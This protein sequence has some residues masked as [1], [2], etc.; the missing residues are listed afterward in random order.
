MI[1][2]ALTLHGCS[3]RTIVAVK[4]LISAGIIALAVAL[5]QVVHIALGQPGGAQFLPMYLPVLLGACLLGARWGAA[6]GVMSPLVS[7]LITTAAGNAMPAAGRLPFMMLELLVF[8]VVAGLFADAISRKAV[9]VSPAVLA[10][11]IC[12]RGAF[13][14]AAYVFAGVSSLAPAMVAAQIVA[15]VPGLLIQLVAVPVIVAVL[16]KLLKK[17]A[18]DRSD[19]RG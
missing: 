3:T 15:G 4:T 1:D 7:F 19:V 9:F 10:A 11:Q 5:P 13:L 18:N 16:S 2:N 17:G 8:A 12:G 6:V 14:L